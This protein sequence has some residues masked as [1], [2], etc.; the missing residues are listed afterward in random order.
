M[1][2]PP[3]LIASEI[4]RRSSYGGRHPLAIERVSAAL[5]LIRAM[6]WLDDAAYVDSQLASIARNADLS[7][8]VL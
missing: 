1:A 3:R 7:R 6:G 8:Y 5:D 4:Y 2:A